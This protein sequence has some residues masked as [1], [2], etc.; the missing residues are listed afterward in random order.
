VVILLETADGEEHLVVNLR[1]GTPKTVRL[2]DG[3]DV[4]TDGLAVRVGPGAPP[5]GGDLRALGA[6]EVRHDRLTDV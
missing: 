4:S 1:P 2:A 5:R 3:R 6:V